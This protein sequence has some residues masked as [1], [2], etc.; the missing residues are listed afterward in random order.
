LPSR[1]EGGTIHKQREGNMNQDCEARDRRI[2]GGG[3]PTNKLGRKQIVLLSLLVS[4]FLL[5][6]CSKSADEKLKD[7]YDYQLKHDPKSAA[8]TKEIYDNRQYLTDDQ[9]EALVEAYDRVRK[10]R[11]VVKDLQ[12][13]GRELGYDRK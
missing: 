11:A 1:T 6:G 8:D 12:E 5:S 10:Q 9:K 13:Q 4:Q 7:M 2:R 3:P